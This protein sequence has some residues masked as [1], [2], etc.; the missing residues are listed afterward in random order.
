[1]R[2]LTK[3]ARMAWIAHHAPNI[4][5]TGI[6][7]T[8]TVRD[9]DNLAAWLRSRGIDALAYHADLGNEQRERLEDQLLRNEVKALVATVALGMGFDKPDLGFVIHF[10][11]AA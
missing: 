6:I 4:P 1:M 10:P 9:A 3:A 11:P 2:I 7:Y 8:L 5:G